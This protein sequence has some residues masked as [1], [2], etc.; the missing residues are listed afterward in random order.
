MDRFS[1]FFAFY[2]LILGLAVTELLGG[3][4]RMVRAKALRQLEA[5]TALLALLTFIVICATWIDAWNTLTQISLDFE[6]LAAPI[7][8][9]TFYFLAAAVVFPSDPAEFG[10]LAAYYADRKRFVV[11]MLLAAEVLVTFTF[12]GIILDM[13][14][15]K[16]AIFW[17]WFLPYNVAI[18]GSYVALLFVRG[19]TA[20]VILLAVLILLFMIP[21]WENNAIA[22]VIARH[23]GY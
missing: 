13:I 10:Q 16:P 8:L 12:R 19:R 5:Q 1:F 23:Y 22:G 17:L 11:A 9:A 4:A 6:A 14:Q 15:N 7:L 20:N 2:G 21:Y 3:F 18:K